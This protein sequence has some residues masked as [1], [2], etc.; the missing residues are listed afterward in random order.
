MTPCSVR[1]AVEDRLA[2]QGGVLGGLICFRRRGCGDRELIEVK[3]GRLV[4]DQIGIVVY[5]VE[6]GLL[7]PSVRTKRLSVQEQ[8]SIEGNAWPR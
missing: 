8:L 7:R 4:G 1:L 6:T 5:L 3:H 2:P